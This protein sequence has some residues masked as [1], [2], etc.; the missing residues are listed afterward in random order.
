MLPFAK[1]EALG[2]DFVLVDRLDDGLPVSPADA[3]WLCDRRRG[4]GADGVLVAWRD[5][6]AHAR[7][8]LFNADGSESAMCG[9]GLR[10]IAHY[11][12]LT[13]RWPEGDETVTLR[14]AVGSHLCERVGPG[15]YRTSMGRADSTHHEL[16][17]ASASGSVP[18]V[19]EGRTFAASCVHLGNPHA[20]IFTEDE[21]P[22][23]L[24][25]RYGATLEHDPSFVART[26]VSFVRRS[27]QRFEAAVH[28]R[29]VG[30][31]LACG[32]G[33]CAIAATAVSRGLWIAGRPLVV[34]MPGGELV[35]TV[36][37]DGELLLEGDVTMSFRGEAMLP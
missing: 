37:N 18:L 13:G 7:M 36:R 21:V 6:G 20:V 15:R 30:A 17:E 29:G 27:A 9:N 10:C 1:L 12:H 16:P 24:V 26:N 2:N 3:R 28:E 8:Q 33:A 31:T 32:S 35:V 25:S 23:D 14:A 34:A 22:S 11:L 4:V 5:V 19:V